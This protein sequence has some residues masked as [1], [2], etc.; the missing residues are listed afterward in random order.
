MLRNAAC[1]KSAGRKD[2]RESGSKKREAGGVVGGRSRK[3]GKVQK[4]GKLGRRRTKHSPYREGT[5][6]GKRGCHVGKMQWI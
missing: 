6:R 4:A 3:M 1:N 5:E 2:V